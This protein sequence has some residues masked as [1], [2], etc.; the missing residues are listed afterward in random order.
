MWITSPYLS[1][2]WYMFGN[3]IW[4]NISPLASWRNVTLDGWTGHRASRRPSS[5]HFGMMN[6][7]SFRNRLH[8]TFSSMS[9][10]VMR[11][12]GA[13]RT[14]WTGPSTLT[15]SDPALL[16]WR[17]LSFRISWTMHATA[18]WTTSLR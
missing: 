10:V 5:L 7:F 11:G 18:C 8:V 13:S 6:A 1:V 12:F 3:A 16:T 2:A 15:D 17:G 14:A 4:T 9:P